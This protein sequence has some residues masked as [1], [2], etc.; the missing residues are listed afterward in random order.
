MDGLRRPGPADLGGRAAHGGLPLLGARERRG[1]RPAAR[2]LPRHGGRAQD[3]RRGRWPCSGRASWRCGPRSS[4]RRPHRSG[5]PGRCGPTI[6]SFRA[7]ASTAWPTA[8]GS[9]R[10]RCCASGAGPGSPGGIPPPSASPRRPSSSAS[11]ALHATGYALGITLDG[12]TSAAVAY[13]GD[14]ATSEGDVAEAFGFAASY[15][16]PVVFFCQNNQWAISE[17][18]R[19]QSHD[20]HRPA[21]PGVRDS[22]DPGR[23]ERRAGRPRRHAA[24]P[25]AR[26][27]R[28]RA[29]AHRSRHL[30]HGAAHDVGRPLPV[31]LARRR[32]GVARQGPARPAACTAPRRGPRRRRVRRAG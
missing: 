7:T 6:S 9:I 20:L 1:R 27:V 14:G 19:V 3:R 11:Q 5:R 28:P 29:D 2:P 4:G 31:P 13:F 26:L 25:G 15:V 10:W 23:R 30:S 24:R 12:G 18:V 17:P 8:G 32:G 16:V 22:R 21:R